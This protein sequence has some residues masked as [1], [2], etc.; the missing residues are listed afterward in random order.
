MNDS[1]VK[2]SRSNG[3]SQRG[4]TLVELMVAMTIALFLLGG[5]FATVQTTRRAYGNQNALAQLQDNQRLAMT[6]MTDVI[7]SAGYFPNP[8]VN[9][10]AVLM[11]ADAT[12]V[13]AGQSMFGTYNAAAPGDTISVRYAIGA[14]PDNA[15]NCIGTTVAGVAVNLFKV[16]ANK[17]LVCTLGGVGGVDFTLISST[18]QNGVRIGVE[19]LSILYGV[20][21]NGA[22]TGSCADTYLRADQVQ[23][24][25][26]WNSV[27]SVRITLNFTN[28][29]NP[30]AA[31][32]PVQRVIAIMNTAGVNT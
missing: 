9:T 22:A 7:E 30:A 25:N 29:I 18:V 17:N 23:A 28:P 31:Q 27:C 8:N 24:G 6:L 3:R 14:A 4:F 21:A 32:I 5:L 10:A 19:S 2:I 20:K 15:L 1:N 13:T 26:Y 11:P 16:D 12:F